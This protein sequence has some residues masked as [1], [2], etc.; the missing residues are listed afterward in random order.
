MSSF[1][2][3]VL[4]LIENP[5]FYKQQAYEDI[6]NFL[7]HLNIFMNIRYIFTKMNTNID[8]DLHTHVLQLIIILEILFY[9]VI[10][11]INFMIEFV[12]GPLFAIAIKPEI[13]GKYRV[14]HL[15]KIPLAPEKFSGIYEDS[16]KN[17]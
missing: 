7:T 16:S 12:V 14:K 15:L 11:H 9:R 8:L 4:N 6:L 17:I 13:D 10:T 3:V 1:P 2:E 5:A